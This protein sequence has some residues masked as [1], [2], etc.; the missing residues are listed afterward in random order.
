[1][2]VQLQGLIKIQLCSLPSPARQGDSRTQSQLVTFLA[3]R[4][5]L[6]NNVPGQARAKCN[7][8][9]MIITTKV[10]SQK[11]KTDFK[12]LTSPTHLPGS[13]WTLPLSISLD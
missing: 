2:A 8:I 7:V 11:N 13:G 1:M 12:F 9:F 5:K 3:H 4:R 6:H 10:I